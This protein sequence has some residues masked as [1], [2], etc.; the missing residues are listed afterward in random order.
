MNA[1]GNCQ[2][3]GD[4]RPCDCIEFG[5]VQQAW[6]LGIPLMQQSVLFAAIRAP[7]GLRKDH[8]VKVLMAAFDV[9]AVTLIVKGGWPI[10]ISSGFGASF[11]MVVA[12][13][14]HDRI[15]GK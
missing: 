4:R 11:G 14:F 3:C 2:A 1:L 13:K 8:P 5:P 6:V 7:D 10:A 15:F 12:I 9:A